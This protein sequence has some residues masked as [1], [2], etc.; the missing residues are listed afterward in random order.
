VRFLAI[1]LKENSAEDYIVTGKSKVNKNICDF[2]GTIK[3]QEVYILDDKQIQCEGPDYS[4]GYLQGIYSFQED[5]TQEQVGDFNGK[6]KLLFNLSNSIPSP[7]MGWPPSGYRTNEFIGI[8][9][10]YNGN[11]PKYC[12]W[13][14][15]IPPAQKNDLFKHYDNEPYLFNP[16]FLAKGWKSYVLANLNSFITIPK[17]FDTKEPRYSKDFDRSYSNEEIQSAI[18]TEKIQWWK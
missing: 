9:K 12:A 17:D 18:E 11:S 15:Q 4:T 5:S 8:W 6:F 1:N 16:Q 10:E 2:V 7:Y 3:I 13:G 14:L